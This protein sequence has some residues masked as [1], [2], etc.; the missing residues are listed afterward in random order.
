MFLQSHDDVTTNKHLKTLSGK[1]NFLYMLCLK[2]KVKPSNQ[3]AGQCFS[4]KLKQHAEI[5]A[6][7]NSEKKKI[8]TKSSLSTI[9]DQTIQLTFRFNNHIQSQRNC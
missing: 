6:K 9:F 2:N 5:Q 3:N 1:A 8:Y 4:V 7:K